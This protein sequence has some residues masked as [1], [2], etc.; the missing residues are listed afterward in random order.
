MTVTRCTLQAP[1]GARGVGATLV[2]TSRMCKISG[3]MILPCSSGLNQAK[4]VG[5]LHYIE[6]QQLRKCQTTISRGSCSA[7]RRRPWT[8]TKNVRN[9]VQRYAYTIDMHERLSTSGKVKPIFVRMGWHR[10]VQ[11]MQVRLMC[12]RYNDDSR[13]VDERHCVIY[14]TE[15][16][17]DLGGNDQSRANREI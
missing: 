13:E 11:P 1:A 6:N 4:G 14:D 7:S 15:D 2:Q 8:T 16:E 10:L 3:V 5:L 12:S 17:A 9:V